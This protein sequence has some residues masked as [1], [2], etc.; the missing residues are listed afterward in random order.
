MVSSSDN[1]TYLFIRLTRD[2]SIS[3]AA[4][5]KQQ[6]EKSPLTGLKEQ[7]EQYLLLGSPIH[8]GRA[9]F[10]THQMPQLFECGQGRI[11]MRQR[12]SSHR[13]RLRRCATL[14]LGCR[15][16]GIQGGDGGA[17]VI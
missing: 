7:P 8:E 12:F 3:S 4:H 13:A 14:H 16:S 11:V 6:T 15:G 2:E 1:S 9:A 17:I 5:T 10:R